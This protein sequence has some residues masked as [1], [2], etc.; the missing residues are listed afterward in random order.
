MSG[1]PSPY[2]TKSPAA[3]EQSA[4][5]WAERRVE[6]MQTKRAMG[7]KLFEFQTRERTLTGR[8]DLE[9]RLLIVWSLIQGEGPSEARIAGA[10][11]YDVPIDEIEQRYGLVL[12]GPARASQEAEG[13][14][15]KVMGG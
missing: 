2:S 4:S 12:L 5:K 7:Q 6:F 14:C 8:V 9:K 15:A 13:I 10:D 3:G 1:Q 11:L